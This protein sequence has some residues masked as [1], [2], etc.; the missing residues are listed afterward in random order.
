MS[1][2]DVLVRNT[3]IDVRN[4]PTLAVTMM[5]RMLKMTATAQ[6]NSMKPTMTGLNPTSW[7]PDIV[8]GEVQPGKQE[9]FFFEKGIQWQGTCEPQV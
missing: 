1:A 8:V 7:G 2:R 3:S 5:T 6:M 9:I 4:L